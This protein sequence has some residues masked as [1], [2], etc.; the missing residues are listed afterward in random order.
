MDHRT[1]SFDIDNGS[2]FLY[3]YGCF[4][5]VN[6]TNLIFKLIY[7]K[8]LPF[9]VFDQIMVRALNSVFEIEYPESYTRNKGQRPNR[10]AKRNDSN[11]KKAFQLDYDDKA[12]SLSADENEYEE[13]IANANVYYDVEYDFDCDCDW[14]LRH[15]SGYLEGYYL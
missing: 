13:V 8:F 15:E 5:A 10:Y 14:C 2:T 7:I 1:Y 12:Q 3:V 11:R 9:R 6:N 4:Y